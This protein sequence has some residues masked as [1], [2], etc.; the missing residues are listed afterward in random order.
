M[1]GL[2]FNDNHKLSYRSNWQSW[3]YKKEF[4]MNVRNEHDQHG[5]RVGAHGDLPI[6]GRYKFH[7]IR[8]S[9][10][11]S[12]QV[13]TVVPTNAFILLNSNNKSDNAC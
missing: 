5:G 6:S 2:F 4:T 9:F 12:L 10:F 11:G 3:E 1:I 13:G 8:N 7:L